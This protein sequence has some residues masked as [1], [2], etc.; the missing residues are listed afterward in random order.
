[1]TGQP[2][3]RT[4]NVPHGLERTQGSHRQ[5]STRLNF[6]SSG[7]YNSTTKHEAGNALTPPVLLDFL[8]SHRGF[9]SLAFVGGSSGGVFAMDTDLARME[10]ERYFAA[11]SS[12]SSPDC[13]GGMTANLTR[14]TPAA[15][16]SLL[17]FGARGRRTP[18]K[19]GVGKPGEG[20]VT[21]AMMNRSRRTPSVAPP[22]GRTRP[23]APA[24]IA[25]CLPG[26]CTHSRRH[27]AQPLCI[28]WSRPHSA[29]ESSCPGMRTPGD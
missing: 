1:M 7:K 9:R 23:A 22:P 21:L 26:P 29:S 10:W 19:S 16:P 12:H 15:M 8:I 17:G 27:A 18:A 28:K 14:P 6:N 20:A 11:G 3:A 24:G 13:P 4:H 5:P 25:R 2:S